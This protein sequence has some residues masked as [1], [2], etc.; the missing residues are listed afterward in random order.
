MKQQISLDYFN[1]SVIFALY[2]TYLL[3]KEKDN[4]KV[5]WLE[6]L[7]LNLPHHHQIKNIDLKTKDF[8][9]LLVFTKIFEL[10]CFGNLG[11]N[12]IMLLLP[13]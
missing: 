8:S 1:I 4:Y 10:F 13:K 3:L 12:F 11:I 5:I 6:F 9:L 7:I 2:P